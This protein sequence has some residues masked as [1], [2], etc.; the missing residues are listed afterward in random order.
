MTDSPIDDCFR[1]AGEYKFI[2]GSFLGLDAHPRQ[3]GKEYEQGRNNDYKPANGDDPT[4]DKISLQE[5]LSLGAAIPA[6]DINRSDNR[7]H[8]TPDRA[9]PIPDIKKCRRDAADGSVETNVNDQL[10]QHLAFRQRTGNH[11]SLQFFDTPEIHGKWNSAFDGPALRR[12]H[13]FPPMNIFD[14]SIT[15]FQQLVELKDFGGQ[16]HRR[17][18]LR[19]EML[20]RF[21]WH[22]RN[23]FQKS[24]TQ[25]E[26]PAILKP[27]RCS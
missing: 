22:P 9:K 18:R 7:E 24:K 6:V 15:K 20:K 17:G 3:C 14:P 4:D 8:N 27:E 1:K 19:L 13:S 23:P 5:M 11:L 16:T 12:R 25:R 2:P 26:I 10:R 21:A